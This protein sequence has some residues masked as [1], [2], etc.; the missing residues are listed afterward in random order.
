MLKKRLVDKVERIGL[1]IQYKLLQ[2][3]KRFVPENALVVA[4][5]PRGGSTWLAELINEIPRTAM[6]WEPLAI[7]NVRQFE[8]LGFGW[9]QYIPEDEEWHEAKIQF[10]LLFSGG[11]LSNYLCLRTSPE[12]LNNASHL[13]VKFCRANQLL[14]WLTKQFD[15]RYSPVYLVR[16][17]CSVVASQMK[18][19]GWDNV[20]AYFEIPAVPFGSFYS[21][22][23]DFLNTINTVEMRLAAWW[24]L[25]NCAPLQHQGNNR[26]WIT[27]TYEQ[28][29][30]DGRKQLNRIQNRWGLELPDSAFQRLNTAS[31]TTIAGSPIQ[32]GKI[33]QQ[34]K[35]WQ[36]QLNTKQIDDVL[37][38]LDYFGVTLYDSDVLP[39]I[40]FEH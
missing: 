5:D 19:G 39:T 27:L 8:S 1:A 18:K 37:S 14:P 12:Q 21:D 35:Y 40:S 15:F 13:L 23:E 10:E 25:C 7:N 9:R 31:K 20:P 33:M 30:L 3:Q 24:C 17:P 11:M 36:T 4:G 32:D 38:V 22:H 26:K 2:S 29:L 6:L 28:L 34:L 16:H